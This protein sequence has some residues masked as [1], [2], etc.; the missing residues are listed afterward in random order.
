M[1]RMASGTEHAPALSLV[2]AVP[3]QRHTKHDATPHV[4]SAYLRKWRGL[5]Q[6]LGEAFEAD[7][8]ILLRQRNERM[9]PVIESGRLAPEA[10]PPLRQ[11]AALSGLKAVETQERVHG[12][13]KSSEGR[14]CAVP[15]YWPD[16]IAYGSLSI[17]TASERST[18]LLK[19]IDMARQLIESDF[20]SLH[21]VRAIDRHKD[22]L[23]TRI[24]ERTYEL[25]GLNA[26]LERELSLSLR[27]GEVLRQMVIGVPGSSGQSYFRQLVQQLALLLQAEHT[28][29]ALLRPEAPGQAR[30]I[31]F[32]SHGTWQEKFEYA[33]AQTPC[34]EVMRRM[35]VLM[36][37]ELAQDY[38]AEPASPFNSASY[39][40]APLLNETGR[41]VGVLAA[42]AGTEIRRMRAEDQLR[43]M[44]LQD[45]LTALPN[46]SN[47][48][49][50]LNQ[51]LAQAERDGTQLALL[52]FDLDNFKTINDSLG[53]DVGDAVLV[54]FAR[55]MSSCLREMD[56]IA[57]LGGDEFAALVP[58]VDSL[59]IDMVC[60]RIMEALGRPL[61]CQ[62]H[63]LFISAS[64]GC[65]LFPDD[66]HDPSSL[67]RAA[68]AAMYRAKAM[69]KN[70]FQF[71]ALDIK[72]AIQRDLT[73]G[74]RLRKAIRD[75]HLHLAYQPKIRLADGALT[76]AEALCRWTD[77][78]LDVVSPAEFIPVAERSGAISE[79]GVLVI[80]MVIQDLLAWRRRGLAL[81]VIAVNVSAKQLQGA[82]FAR[83][84]GGL[85]R[86]HELSPANLAIELTEGVLMERSETN[87]Q[88]LAELVGLGFSISVDDFGTGYSSLAYLKRMPISELK[89]DR[90]FVRN[91]AEDPDDQAIAAAILTLAHTLKL[92]VV[93]EG[94]EDAHQLAV[95]QT[96][97]C[98]AAQGYY[99]HKP[100]EPAVFSALL[101]PV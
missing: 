73:V 94:V 46:R 74:N 23:E 35:K 69:G 90:S 44:A 10:M 40:G 12:D 51:A 54:E 97:H 7:A 20:R 63:E 82:G 30:T 85:L 8:L 22:M 93:A 67:I 16:K 15:L 62:D 101:Q 98:D 43:R 32:Y 70:Q 61:L 55:T 41:A 4:P 68:D 5:L 87:Q 59:Q 34:T 37:A 18:A 83:W 53:H 56:T 47:F 60:R 11:A 58:C 86:E 95:L 52:F 91:L 24:A 49:D 38:P 78:E 21:F 80:E 14:H 96:L 81:P 89:I 66:G 19:L 42:R 13:T 39:I 84:L 33:V 65:C 75:R 26:R 57:R 77:A 92:S 99:F 28:F 71:Y 31:A 100:L 17:F 72:Q 1:N 48:K 3:S 50:R 45:E 2:S 29:V 79:L 25:S 27:T 76:G 6:V 36:T 88:I 64:I 9:E